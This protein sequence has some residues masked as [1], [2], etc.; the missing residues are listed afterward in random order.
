VPL[1]E[2]NVGERVVEVVEVGGWR[3]GHE[4]LRAAG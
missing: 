2:Q 3:V 4:R 1:A